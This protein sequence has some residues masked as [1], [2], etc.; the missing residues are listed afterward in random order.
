MLKKKGWILLSSLKLTY[1]KNNRDDVR[2][3]QILLNL[4]NNAV[5]YTNKGSVLLKIVK[6]NETKTT[7]KYRFSVNDTGIGISREDI[8]HLFK[9]FS[10]FKTEENKRIEGTGLGLSIVKDTVDLLGGKLGVET[11]SGI[12]STF[13]FD[14][15]YKKFLKKERRKTS[16]KHRDEYVRIKKKLKILVADDDRFSRIIIEK[17]LIGLGFNLIDMVSN[18][19]E[20]VDLSATNDYDIIF[21]DYLM[22]V[23]NGSKATAMIR[24]NDRK[25]KK[26]T[27]IIA[28]SADILAES[29]EKCFTDGMD[30]FLLKPINPKLLDNTLR[31]IIVKKMNR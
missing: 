28:L 13:W 14:L 12:G 23:L 6:I 10:Q 8:K 2:L 1:Q 22:P 25:D 30:Y 4:C 21:M 27:C 20:V 3:E 15:K 26:R 11:I 19:Q 31:E 29:R 16:D 17:I 7:V 18:G 24:K 5:K 9:P